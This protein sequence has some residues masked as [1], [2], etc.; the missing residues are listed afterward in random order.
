MTPQ[1]A[2]LA[3][4]SAARS[5][6]RPLPPGRMVIAALG[7]LYALAVLWATLRPVSWATAGAQESLGILSP[8]AWLDPASWIDG[9]P[10]EVVFNVAMFIPIGVTASLVL[11]GRRAIVLPLVLTLGIELAQIPLDRISHPRDLVANAVGGLLGIAAV[12]LA[13]RGGSG[14]SGAAVA[15]AG[16]GTAASTG[17]LPLR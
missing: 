5:T 16:P 9:R 7:A 4:S 10:L 15:H 3:S 13:R 17:S 2:V 6:A 14:R 1:T 11:G 8:A 12:A